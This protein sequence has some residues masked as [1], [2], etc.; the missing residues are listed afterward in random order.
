MTLRKAPVIADDI[1]FGGPEHVFRRVGDGHYQ[2]TIVEH[3]IEFDADRLW[4]EKDELKGE[5]SVACGLKGARTI[6]GLLSTGNFNFSASRTRKEHGSRLRERARTGEAVDWDGLLEELCLRVIAAERQGQPARLLHTFD[7]PAPD[8]SYEIDGMVLLKRHPVMLFGDGGTAKSYLGLYLAG[9]LAR[10]GVSVLFADWELAGEDHRERL[11]KLFGDHLPQIHYVRCA[12]PLVRE[13]DQLRRQIEELGIHYV[14]CDSVAFAADGA[15]E[16]AE[17]AMAYFRAVRQ[18]GVGSLHIA[19]VTK[20][21][22]DDEKGTQGNQKPFGSTFWHNSARATWYVKRADDTTDDGRVTIGLY[23]RKANMGRLR[24][25][26]GYEFDFQAEATYVSRANLADVADLASGLPIRAR[27]QH[28]LKHGPLTI[29]G[30]AEE[31]G[32][33]PDSVEKAL[34][35]N[36]MFLRLASTS[37]GVHQWGLAERNRGE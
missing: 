33:R 30:L 20:Q 36:P 25:A 13:A 15:P 16:S 26:V 35:R 3:G 27:L 14:M 22:D 29:A 17:V 21:R 19:H 5:L 1:H 6:D 7:L 18:M 24:P 11:G 32:A 37:T 2:L 8:E 4:R 34:K 28:A 23:N 10:R 9:Q 31:I 12:H